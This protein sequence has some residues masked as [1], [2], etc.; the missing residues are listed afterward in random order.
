MKGLGDYGEVKL[1]PKRE[2]VK[3][4]VYPGVLAVELFPKQRL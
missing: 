1:V 3:S 2:K 4:S